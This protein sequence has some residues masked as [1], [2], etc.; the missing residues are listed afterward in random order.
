M[1]EGRV[2]SSARV[3]IPQSNRVAIG[4]SNGRTGAADMPPAELEAT[5]YFAQWSPDGT[6]VAATAE[7]WAG[8]WNARDGRPLSPP[9]R[10]N[11]QSLTYCAFS[12]D[13]EMLATAGNDLAVRL[14]DGHTGRA[15][16]A[17]L[18]HSDHP[19]K[20]SFSSDGGRLATACEDGTL[21]VWSV[22]E[23]KLVLGPLHHS[24]I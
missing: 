15:L 20:I 21:R 11:G 23:G 17:P 4:F 18:T 16:N 7:L 10:H 2:E 13:G 8:I 12:P 1:D 6:R 3:A 5:G 22:P 19:L 9:L 24:G 14:W